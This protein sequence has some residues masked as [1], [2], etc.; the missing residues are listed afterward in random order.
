MVVTHRNIDKLIDR[1]IENGNCYY[2]VTTSSGIHNKN[3]DIN[4]IDEAAD[5]LQKF[6]KETEGSEAT[7]VINTFKALPPKGGLKKNSEADITLTY[8]GQK[9]TPEEKAEW[10][11]NRSYFEEKLIDEIQTLKDIVAQQNAIIN[12]PEETELEHE[13]EGNSI[14]GTIQAVMEIPQVQLITNALI[15]AITNK[16]LN[17]T[18][19]IKPMAL[20]GTETQPNTVTLEQILETLFKKGVTIEHLYKLSQFDESKIKMLLTML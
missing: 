13:A 6:F 18:N 11:S 9:Y 4:D 10:K 19:T 7:Y 5:K 14:L 1:F 3:E 15:G 12:S 8:K 17:N 2:T 16:F 20:A